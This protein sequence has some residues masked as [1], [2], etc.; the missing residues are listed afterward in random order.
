[1][2]QG[3]REFL[4]PGIRAGVRGIK[5]GV[6]LLRIDY[7]G[8]QRGVRL[9]VLVNLGNSL[10]LRR[11]ASRCLLAGISWVGDESPRKAP[12]RDAHASKEQ[13]TFS[14]KRRSAANLVPRRIAR[15]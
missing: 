3:S 8:E 15:Q 13:A 14:L 2:V 10:L 11:E 5:A 12:K 6:R 4:G 9:S 1:M 7:L